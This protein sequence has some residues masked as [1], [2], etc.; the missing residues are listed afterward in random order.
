MNLNLKEKV[1]IIT[2]GSRGIGEGL[3]KAFA[4]EGCKVYFTYIKNVDRSNNIIEELSEKN[5]HVK[6]FQID[7]TKII[8]VR[9]FIEMV[10]KNEGKIDVLINN[11]GYI[12]RELFHNTTEDVWKKCIDTNINGIYNY[13]KNVLKY[14]VFNKNGSIINISSLSANQPSI[15]QSAYG[16]SKAAIESLS[17]VLAIE[18]GKKNI[19]INTVAPALVLE[20]SEHRN[21]RQEKL[22]EILKKTPL[23]R[24]AAI[25]D[26]VNSVMFLAS[27][28]ANYLTGIQLL[29]TGGRHLI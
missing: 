19:R 18:Y 7:G 16:A 2:G 25:N 23:N 5:L 13:C 20:K 14:M 1:V 29:V 22:D 28:E 26:V 17:K 10:Y 21:I 11:A 15:G 8:D 27:D 9:K 3:V 12:P 4:E 6:G 24:F